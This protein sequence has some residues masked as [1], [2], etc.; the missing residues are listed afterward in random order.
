MVVSVINMSLVN[1]RSLLITVILF[2]YISIF[3]GCFEIGTPSIRV[4]KLVLPP[5]SYYNLSYENLSKY[6][7][8]KEALENPGV[9]VDLTEEEYR[10]LDNFLFRENYAKII[11]YNG[12][13]YE[14]YLATF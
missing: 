10:K 9:R 13:Y 14:I 6:P 12:S 8:L 7:K 1:N 3:V 4:E 5:E 11:K 2:F